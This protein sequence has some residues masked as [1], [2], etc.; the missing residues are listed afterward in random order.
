MPEY[1]TRYEPEHVHEGGDAVRSDRLLRVEFMASEPFGELPNVIERERGIDVIYIALLR[2][3]NVGGNNKVEMKR[4][5]AAFEQAGMTGVETYIN[6]GNV[7]FACEGRSKPDIVAA[8]EEQIVEAFGFYVKV[9]LRDFDEMTA[10][11]EALPEEWTNDDR[12]KSDALF[13]WD[14]VSEADVLE[15]AKAKPGIDTPIF[16]P[17]ANALLWGVDRGNATRSGLPKLI[18][19]DVYQHIT[20]R[21]VNTTRKIYAMMQAKR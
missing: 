21:N 1:G 4:L 18:G 11:I 2:G 3:I 6:S 15:V 8:L 16:V 20:I 12:M 13:L 19:T 5:K 7:V 9:T 17:S 10:V 14:G